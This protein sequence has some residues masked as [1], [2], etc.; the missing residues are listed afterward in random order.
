MH[1]LS[2]IKWRPLS[3]IFFA[4]L[5]FWSGYFIIIFNDYI[6]WDSWVGNP[7]ITAIESGRP[8]LAP[9]WA[10]ISSSPKYIALARFFN[11]LSYNLTGIFLY[12]ILRKVKLFS[13][14][15][16][17]L[18]TLAFLLVPIGCANLIFDYGYYMHTL[19]LFTLASFFLVVS[20]ESKYRLFLVFLSAVLFFLSFTTNS[21]LVFYCIP[22]A[23]ICWK[24]FLFSDRWRNRIFNLFVTNAIFFLL[25]FM[26][27]LL[28]NLFFKPYGAYLNYNSIRIDSILQAFKET[29]G[30]D[31]FFNSLIEPIQT[32]FNN[33]GTT[34]YLSAPL[35]LG[36]FTY[37]NSRITPFKNRS[38]LRDLLFVSVGILLIT[39]ATIPYFTVGNSPN[40]YDWNSRN[41]LLVPFGFALIFVFTILQTTS[42]LNNNHH[43]KILIFSLTFAS[44]INQNIYRMTAYLL[45][46]LKQ[47]S[48]AYHLKNNVDIKPARTILFFDRMPEYNAQDRW[49]RFYEYT[50][51][52]KSIYGDETRFASASSHQIKQLRNALAKEYL[53]SSRFNTR[54]YIESNDHYYSVE[55]VGKE[56]KYFFNR[57]P[58]HILKNIW[59][60]NYNYP[61]YENLLKELMILNINRLPNVIN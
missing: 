35:F 58:M 25:P 4:S 3:F 42:L 22:Y 46:G 47:A 17:Q 12:F 33:F 6:Y 21:L 26:F 31:N 53:Y 60:K 59:Y 36:I 40:Q 5:F 10:T 24:S 41:Q 43:L 39:L 20:Y 55:I 54:D 29:F 9:I 15:E 13:E 56:N 34:W 50:G 27:F 30:F 16:D 14:G 57:E 52:L 11:C 49:Y 18:I 38:F 37:L 19:F 61:E 7:A 28:I 44:F 32:S 2:K 48:L 51:I 23:F 45:D 1:L 8:W